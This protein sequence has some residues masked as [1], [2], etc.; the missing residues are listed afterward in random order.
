MR[1]EAMLSFGGAYHSSDNKMDERIDHDGEKR[2]ELNDRRPIPNHQVREYALK[3]S[4]KN[5]CDFV[6]PCNERIT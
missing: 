6:N 2:R 3:G 1:Y 4:A 5:L